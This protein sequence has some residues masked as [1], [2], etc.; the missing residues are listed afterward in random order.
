MTA[1]RRPHSSLIRS[2]LLASVSVAAI[3]VAGCG[4]SAQQ[5]SKSTSAAAAVPSNK[6]AIVGTGPA[7]PAHS[8]PAESNPDI[9]Q[10]SAQ[11]SGGGRATSNV[12]VAARPHATSVDRIGKAGRTQRARHPAADTENRGNPQV[13][14]PCTL[15]SL[16]EAQSF[17]G[18]GVSGAIE[19]PLGPTCIFKPSTHSGSKTEITLALESNNAEQLAKHLGRRQELTVSGHHAYC[20]HLG[21][22]LLVVPLADGQMLS[23]SAPCAVARQFATAALNRLEA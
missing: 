16:H 2:A 4:S 17:T 13:L 14:N 22:Q 23:V 21:T 19:A 9:G 18:G 5:S 15:V 20:G 8:T 3:A 1:R 7:R 11:G 10:A 6:A 12:K